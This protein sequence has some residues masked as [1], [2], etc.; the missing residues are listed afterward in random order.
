MKGRFHVGKS[1]N[2]SQFNAGLT[3]VCF[4]ITQEIQEVGDEDDDGEGDDGC[5]VPTDGNYFT[6]QKTQRKQR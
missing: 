6:E 1:C 2:V 4:K 3:Q 5:R